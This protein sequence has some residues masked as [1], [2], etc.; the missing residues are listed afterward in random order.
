MVRFENV[1]MQKLIDLLQRPN[2]LMLDGNAEQSSLDCVFIATNS[3]LSLQ[4]IS[5]ASL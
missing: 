4:R 3:T 2:S 1:T 5:L